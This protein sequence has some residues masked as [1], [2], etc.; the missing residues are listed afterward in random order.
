MKGFKGKAKA[1]S[2]KK[3]HPELQSDVV[4]QSM[5]EIA[6]KENETRLS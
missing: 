6:E 4:P 5:K 3:Q 1:S 2:P